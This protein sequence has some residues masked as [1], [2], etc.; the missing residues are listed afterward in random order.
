V[1]TTTMD[2]LQAEIALECR[3]AGLRPYEAPDSE[4][5]K[6][7]RFQISLVGFVV[8]FGVVF[9]T[10]RADLWGADEVGWIDPDLVRTVMITCAGAFIAY[11]VEKERHLRRLDQLGDRA[12]QLHLVAA[13]RIIED[14]TF[15]E[16]QSELH[17]SLLLEDVLDR[18]LEGARELAGAAGGILYLLRDDLTVTV[19]SS[20][21]DTEPAAKNLT[22]LGQR[23]AQTGRGLLLSRHGL[24]ALAGGAT[25]AAPVRVNGTLIGVVALVAGATR[26]F[27][28]VDLE[29]LDR[30]CVRSG[31]ALANACIYEDALMQAPVLDEPGE[32]GEPDVDLT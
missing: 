23:V 17:E 3:A 11:V 22:S 21:G 6:R 10:L 7:R 4:H 29:L 27:D 2:D 18:A 8:F 32:R 19:W 24:P 28:A 30:F 20:S 16:V 9:S 1:P 14:A 31:R 25:M 12:R 5:I 15:G 26:A 13:E